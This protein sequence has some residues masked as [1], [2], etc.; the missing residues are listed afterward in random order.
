MF[1]LLTSNTKCCPR[2]G[3]VDSSRKG[4]TLSPHQQQQQQRRRRR[5]RRTTVTANTSANVNVDGVVAVNNRNRRKRSER[6]RGEE[7][8]KLECSRC[9]FNHHHHRMGGVFAGASSSSS[10]S[11]TS[12][13]GRNEDDESGEKKEEEEEEVEEG[14][15]S[16]SSSDSDS[17]K[18]SKEENKQEKKDILVQLSLSLID[19][20]RNELSPFM[21]KSCR[22]IP[23]CSNYA[24]EAY[25]KYGAGKGFIL[26][27]WR[28]AR[29]NPFGGRGYDPPRWPPSFTR[30]GDGE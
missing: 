17:D 27:A 24:F 30:G 8:L 18:S 16:S 28:I 19:F 15:I 25:T 1:T 4:R 14:N 23:S 21:P 3:V 10:S 29:C 22:F 2:E 5:E 26:T 12:S 11:L 7:A 9:V 13:S 20:Y 6:R